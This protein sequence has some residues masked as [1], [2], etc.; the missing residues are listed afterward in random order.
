M[1]RVMLSSRP[2][3]IIVSFF[4]CLFCSLFVLSSPSVHAL[5]EAHFARMLFLVQHAVVV[6]WLDVVVSS[7][8]VIHLITASVRLTRHVVDDV[9]VSTAHAVGCKAAGVRQAMRLMR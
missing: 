6:G 8:H 4:L 7:L 1:N 9:G 2:S 3:C 5:V